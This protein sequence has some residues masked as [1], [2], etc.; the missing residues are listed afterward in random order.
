MPVGAKTLGIIAGG[1][2]FPRVVAEAAREAGLRVVAV[3]HEG[4]TDAGLASSVDAIHWVKLGQLSKIIKA[5]KR[6]GAAETVLAGGIAKRG[7]F[8]RA[9]PD[10]RAI[11]LL[12]RMKSRNDDALL[13]ALADELEG[14]GLRVRPATQYLG[15]L[16]APKG[17]LSR[18]QPTA[19]EADDIEF[20]WPI[21][22][23]IGRL[24]VGQAIAVKEKVV[25]A[26]EG[27]EGTDAMIRRAGHLAGGGL[28][29]LKVSKPG[30]DARFDLPAV[31]P[32]TIGA[33][34]E[35]GGGCLA[36]EA[37]RTIVLERATL[38]RDAGKAGV[39]V[40]GR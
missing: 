28:V 24:D 17:I 39:A 26:V 30:Q 22:R 14:E 13:R 6:E 12:A 27:I 7:M 40:V 20:G 29:V 5:L 9:R 37:G 31:G 32:G 15:A 34:A 8:G 36:V 38:V 11:R 2:L 21:A 23:E 4:E 18:R 25:V 19:R 33:I 1:G 10:L 35:A 3:G 16:L